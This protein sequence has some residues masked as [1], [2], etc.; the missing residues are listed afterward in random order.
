MTRRREHGLSLVELM[1]AMV[2]SL[3][4]LAGVIQIYIANS[5]TNRLQEANARV[6]E[7]GRFAVQFL[8][9][10]VRGA[11]YSGCVPTELLQISIRAK[12]AD[13]DDV[14]STEDSL[15]GFDDVASGNQ[16]DAVAGT[17]VVRVTG[18]MNSSVGLAG[19]SFQNDANVQTT[20]NPNNW[21]KG[22]WLFV[23]DCESGDL[24]EVTNN[25]KDS[26][27]SGPRFTFTH[28]ASGNQSS[29]LSKVY[30]SDA[31]L[32]AFEETV[33]FVAETGRTATDG[34][35]IRAL[36]R[37]TDGG[38]AEE[39]IEG[40]SDLQIVYGQD[41]DDS[42]DIDEYVTAD[43]LSG[44]DWAQ[45]LAVRM[46]LLIESTEPNVLD[47]PQEYFFDGE[48]V[49][50]DAAEA[51]LIEDRRLRRVFTTTAVIRNRTP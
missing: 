30:Q 8:A 37:E 19:N 5:Q 31:R 14:P 39:L 15:E 44:D 32:M 16:W 3:I 40:V 34:D 29:K 38:G 20:G 50:D 21:E 28:A 41:T 46:Q 9:R 13:D 42:G 23:A 25:P 24:F 51:T 47:D 10:D 18:A 11:G 49:G 45:V 22:D 35:A 27:H 12:D 48:T 6:Q 7:N 4:L 33:Y 1:V 36:Y 2:I 43:E 26:T 17:D